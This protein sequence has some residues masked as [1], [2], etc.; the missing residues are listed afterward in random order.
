MEKRLDPKRIAW[1]HRLGV[2]VWMSRG[3]QAE[4]V[5]EIEAQASNVEQAESDQFSV[6]E[7]KFRTVEQI[8]EKTRGRDQ[9]ELRYVQEPESP[10]PQS[11]QPAIESESSEEEIAVQLQCLAYG[12]ALV[13]IDQ[14]QE[15][16]TQLCR[17]IAYA[18]SGYANA[19]M[20]QLSFDWPP[21]GS[22]LT[23]E[24]SRIGGMSSVQR[25]LKSLVVNHKWDAR[26]LLIVGDMAD[27]ATRILQQEDRKVIRIPTLP[28]SPQAKRRLWQQILE[29]S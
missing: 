26:L 29:Q 9:G 25:A 17:G 7:A 15:D 27:Q 12:D 18:M 14:D 10:T 23:Q 13:V 3:S 28:D 16:S 22:Q 6:N 21:G 19:E 2:D 1:L 5:V 4:T 11:V 24:H 8:E 20:H